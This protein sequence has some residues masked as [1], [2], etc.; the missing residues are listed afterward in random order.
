MRRPY[1]LMPGASGRAC[2][3]SAQ[4]GCGSHRATLIFF[5]AG[6]AFGGAAFEVVDGV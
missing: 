4:I 6:A 1:S 2:P 5:I 3:T